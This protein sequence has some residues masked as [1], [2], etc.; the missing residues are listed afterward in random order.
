MEKRKKKENA[1]TKCGLLSLCYMGGHP[2]P[3][4]ST[5]G[6]TTSGSS[7]PIQPFSSSSPRPTTN[8]VIITCGTRTIDRNNDDD[9]D[10]DGDDD[11]VGGRVVQSYVRESA[12]NDPVLVF[13]EKRTEGTTSQPQ[14]GQTFNSNFQIFQVFV[15]LK[16]MKCKHEPTQSILGGR[17]MGPNCFNGTFCIFTLTRPADQ[18]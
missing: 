1:K 6:A 14:S 18:N 12:R 7:H 2:T 17:V 8:N 13:G 15:L 11:D 3:S 16:R 4:T 5:R 10:N 9:E